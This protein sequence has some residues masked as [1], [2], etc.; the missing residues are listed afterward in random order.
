MTQRL[1]QLD[2]ARLQ[3]VRTGRFSSYDQRGRNQDGWVIPPG[4]SRVL[5]QVGGP[6]AITHFFITTFVR[7]V[8]GPGFLDPLETAETAPVVE[9]HNALGLNWEESD[10]DYYRKAIIRITWDHAV[11]PAVLVPLGDFFGIGHSIP[12]NY[13]SALFTVSAKPEEEHHFGGSAAMNCYLPMP[14]RTHAKIELV[15][16]GD[17]PLFAYFH[18]DYELYR[19]DLPDDIAYFH[20]SWHRENPCDGWAPDLQVNTPEVNVPNLDGARNYVVADIK[21]AGHYIGC[22]LSVYAR[23]GTWWGEGDDMIFVDGETW[24]PSYHGTGTEDYLTHAWGMQNNSALYG[25]S[26]LHESQMPETQRY[27]VGFRFHVVDPIR[28]SKSLQVTIEHGHANHLSDDWAS[29][30]YWYQTDPAGTG[31][32]QPVAERLP[33][34]ASDPGNTAPPRSEPPGPPEVATEIAILRE[35]RE[36][37]WRAYERSMAERVA[38]RVELTK[39]WEQGS[40]QAAT[41]IRESF[42]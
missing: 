27:S 38:A 26:I 11:H 42:R 33:S 16:E 35:H 28:F 15:N 23:Q 29:T 18:I 39:H 22:N 31:V 30:A 21:G 1:P 8:L 40:R 19:R 4:E 2:M 37:R 36:K 14:F 32:I 3:D 41:A 12:S 6:G 34:R 9:M 7:R 13:Q 25:G 20:A 5:G 24:P 10:P 17:L